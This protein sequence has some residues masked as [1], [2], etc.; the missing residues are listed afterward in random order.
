VCRASAQLA[1]TEHLA[2]TTAI[3]QQRAEE[4]QQL[5]V[6]HVK[7]N[8]RLIIDGKIALGRAQGAAAPPRTLGG[9]R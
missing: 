4:A 9:F 8:M 1:F 7:S 3:E 2:I 5:A 6:D